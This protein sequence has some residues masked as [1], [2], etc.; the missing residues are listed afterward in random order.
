MRAM[1]RRIA[2]ETA[3][4]LG[5]LLLAI[6]YTWPLAIRLSTTVSDLGD[7]LLN[8]WILD[9]T[10][11]ALLH[12]PLRLFDAPMFY[13]S[14]MPLA[15][16][17]HLTGMALLVLPFH[18]AGAAP[19]TLHNIAMLIGFALSGYGAFVLARM[20]VR[21]F[22]AALIG[23]I[24]YAFVSFKFDHLA[25]LQ[26]VSSGWVPLTLAGLIAY[27]RKPS[28]KRGAAFAAALAMNG[29]TNIYFL[30][31]SA[32]ALGASIILLCFVGEKRSVRFWIGLFTALGTAVLV[33]LPF[34]LPYR[35]V[36]EK[37]NMKRPEHE[38]RSGSGE[39]GDWLRSNSRSRLYGDLVPEDAH[40][41]E[42]EVF[43]GLVAVFLLGAAIVLTQRQ[44]PG[45]NGTAGAG[46]F[47]RVLD[48]TIVVL[49][50]AVILGL[51]AEPRFRLSLLGHL[52][53]SLRGSDVTMVAL[54]IAVLGRLSIRLPLA[55]GGA[56]SRSLRD[57]VRDSRFT[58][59]AWIALLWIV[60][61]VLGTLGLKTFFY[62]FLFERIEAYQSIRAPGRWAV[63]TFA[64]LAV[65]VALGV[66]ALLQRRNG[67]S[68]RV[69]AG[70]LFIVTIVDLLPVIQW[71]QV[72][73]EIAP[74]YRFMKRERVAPVVEWPVDNWLVFRY[75]LG[76]T[77]H[78][79][80]LMNGSSGW[81]GPLYRLMRI[82]WDEQKFARAL[83]LAE[84]NGC[85]MLVVHAHWVKESQPVRDVLRKAVDGK[86]I[87]FLR[88]FDHGVEGDFVFAVTRNLPDWQRLRAKDTPDGA[89]H[90]P[91]QMLAAF[92]AGSPTYS[93][94]TF[95]RMESPEWRVEGPLR[96]S[97]WAIS[98][99]GIRQ[100]YALLD[101]GRHRFEA[102]RT[103]RP[104]ITKGFPWYYEQDP[105]FEVVIPQRPRGIPRHTDVQIE[106]IDGAG[107]RTRLDD[108][109]F[110]WDDP[111]S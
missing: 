66:Q 40:R 28:W 72:V 34:L 96:V 73:T 104:E 83:D 102:R 111:S 100:V 46:R 106:I 5:Y 42:H 53:I 1:L 77:H 80:M 105:G 69:L 98:P 25:H 12:Q 31:F 110:T 91:D 44:G 58:V 65:W 47:L 20:F 23:G 86:R 108:Q 75:L 24:V 71:E 61:G 103:K 22:S 41:G 62:S 63:I 88:R 78:R 95:G 81:E 92:L 85:R 30:L 50:G 43:P 16:S 17:E 21:S 38:V 19:I 87:A 27:W 29:L 2:R 7:P 3:V 68:R 49:A 94:A 11:Y 39:W 37:Y 109:T 35:I 36:S 10:S 79:V 52:I 32:P 107:I 67:T 82:A 9:W 97:G 59:E 51:A 74:V 6:G 89:G 76:S 26:I 70:I 101:E 54:L 84:A 93:N 90:L 64:G 14:L 55:L 99:R 45:G 33:L 4:F 60:L 13:P 57:S 48:L 56:D 8:A 15:Y 18:V